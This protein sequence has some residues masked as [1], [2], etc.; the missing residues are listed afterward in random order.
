M[1]PAFYWCMVDFK[2]THKQHLNVTF[3]WLTGRIAGFCIKIWKIEFWVF[4]VA[5]FYSFILF[6]SGYCFPKMGTGWNETLKKQLFLLH[7]SSF[8]RDRLILSFKL[9]LIEW[10]IHRQRAKKKHPSFD[11]FIDLSQ[12]L[13]NRGIPAIIFPVCLLPGL[14]T[15]STTAPM[16]RWQAVRR[17]RR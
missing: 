2:A 14:G 5:S 3:C 12:S 8:W 10:L 17:R 6:A 16:W 9:K 7:R 13:A 4:I 15:N 11:S 1:L